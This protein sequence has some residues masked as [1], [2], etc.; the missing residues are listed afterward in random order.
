MSKL[1]DT[2]SPLYEKVKTYVLDAIVS[3]AWPRIQ[4]MTS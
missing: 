4:R 1:P 3:G 2:A